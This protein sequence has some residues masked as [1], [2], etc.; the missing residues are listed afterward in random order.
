MKKLNVLLFIFIIFAAGTIMV[1]AGTSYR[2]Y[3]TTVGK[4]NG[5]GYTSF[6]TKSVSGANGNLQSSMVGGDYLVDARMQKDDG[7]SGK[8]TRDITDDRYY[9]LDGHVNHFSGDNIRIQFS[10][11]WNTVV[12]VQVTGNWRSN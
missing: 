1:K 4:L 5:N 6:Q 9:D 10:N 11:D 12:D 3:S 8:W 7:V 2:E